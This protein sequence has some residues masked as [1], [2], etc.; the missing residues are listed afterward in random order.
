[1]AITTYAELK[2]AIGD[3]LNNIRVDS[4]LLLRLGGGSYH[5]SLSAQ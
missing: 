1:M 2:T 5:F 4:H 3:W